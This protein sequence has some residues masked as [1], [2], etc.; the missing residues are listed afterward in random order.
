MTRSDRVSTLE[1]AQAQFE[2]A[3]RQW[4]AW[5]KLREVTQFLRRDRDAWRPYPWAA[6]G[7]SPLR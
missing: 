6:L 2:T 4:L 5:A 1:E 3:W 7:V